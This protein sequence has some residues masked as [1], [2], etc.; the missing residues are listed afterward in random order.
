M[1]REQPLAFCPQADATRD[2][3]ESRL[4]KAH[5]KSEDAYDLRPTDHNL[6]QHPLTH[7]RRRPRTPQVALREVDQHHLQ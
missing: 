1:S 5:A 7:P 4:C 3:D 6:A 2:G